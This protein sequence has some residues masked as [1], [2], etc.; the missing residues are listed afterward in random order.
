MANTTRKCKQFLDLAK[1]FGDRD[2]DFI[3]KR[4]LARA[5]TKTQKKYAIKMH[6]FRTR[7][8]KKSMREA[9]VNCLNNTLSL[10]FNSIKEMKTYYTLAAAALRRQMV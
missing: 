4:E 7:K 6:R 3:F 2:E 8:A 9:K 10:P 1:K 5:R